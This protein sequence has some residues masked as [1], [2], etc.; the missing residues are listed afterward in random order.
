MEYKVSVIVTLYNYRKYV[1]D[2]V[3]SFL[4][5]DFADSEMII[6]DDASTDKPQDIINPFLSDR[7]RYIQLDK[8][9]GYSHA[10][11]VGI[12][13]SKS[14]ILVM[15]DADDMLTS[16]SITT[17]Y[18]KMMEG[19]DFVHGPVLDLKKGNLSKS[20]MW[21]DWKRT[22][23]FKYVHAQSV[24][25]KK[26]IHRNIGLYDENLRCKS[27]RE[28]FARIFNHGFNISFVKT[29]VAIYRHHPRQMHRSKEKLLINK[30]L[31]NTVLQK[32]EDRKKD[33]S[34]LEMLK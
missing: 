9:Y 15:L 30:H 10:K 3:K 29:P 4:D 27:D 12:K 31:Q 19:F 22:R 8:N 14:E 2:T 5:Q 21:N 32:I 34:G 13:E 7:I 6:V 25:L 16:N 1:T 18:E 26:D 17:R 28:M 23:I 33:L 11:N 20:R 24:M